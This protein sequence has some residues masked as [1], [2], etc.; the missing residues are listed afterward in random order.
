MTGRERVKRAATFQGPDR[1]PVD[2]P[3][4]YGSDIIM[5]T[6]YDDPAW[7]PSIQTETEWEDEWHCIWHRIPGDTSLGQVKHHPLTDYSMLDSFVFPNYKA[8]GRYDT[9]GKKAAEN[10]CGENRFVIG[11]IPL[12]LIHRLEYLRGHDQAWTDPYLNPGPLCRLLDVICNIAIDAI[13]MYA[14]IGVDG[15]FSNDDWGL[16]DRPIVRPKMWNEFWKPRYHR[17]YSY[18]HQKGLITGLHSCG[19]IID[20]LNGFMEAELDIIQMDQQENMGL[21]N[22]ARRFGG[23]LCFWCPVDIQKTMIEG[24]VD[25]I[26]AYA[27]RLIEAFGK[28]QGG[29]IAKWYPAP[30]AAGHDWEKVKAMA[31]AFLEYGR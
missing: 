15:V 6:A 12:S 22:L 7:C 30:E 27:K 13:D 25:D 20:L 10:R 2:L 3:D 23:R 5:V 11:K 28:Y 18:A 8:A 16:Q 17:V 21:D 24:S 26:R 29:F 4:P 1:V 14:E 9:A 31:E 19:Y